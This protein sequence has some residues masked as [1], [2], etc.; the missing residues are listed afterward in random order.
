MELFNKEGPCVKTEN[1]GGREGG[2]REG[3]SL[4]IG[5]GGVRGGDCI[6]YHC[7]YGVLVYIVTGKT[8]FAGGG[9]F[10]LYLIQDLPSSPEWSVGSSNC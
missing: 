4:V 1:K 10:S 5:E 9:A 3:V 6:P 8:G 2:G 7:V